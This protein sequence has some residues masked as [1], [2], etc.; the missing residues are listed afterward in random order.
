[1]QFSIEGNYPVLRCLLNRGE[2]IKTSAGAMSWM[3]DG[4][5]LEVKSGGLRKGIARMFS[6]ESLFLNYY[7]ATK[8]NQEIVFA[9]SLPGQIKHIKMEGQ[10]IIAQKSAYLASEVSVEFE[11]VFTKRFSS[12]LLGGEGFILQKFSGY[13]DLFLEADGSLYEYDLRPGE[14]ML[15]D[16]GHVFL[17]EESVSYD[18]E[19]IRG[20]KNILFGGE[21]MF[22]VRL[23]GPGRVI[24]QSMPIANLAAKIVPYVP[25]SSS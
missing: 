13:G 23:T 18:I 6:G 16:Q 21:G 9:S 11:T 14:S 25:T 8:D 24:L 12:G 17:F 1:M 2:T 10:R 3:S 7:T 15:V 22:L 20:M 5:D 4:F 19:T